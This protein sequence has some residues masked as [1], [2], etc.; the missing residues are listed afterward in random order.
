MPKISYLSDNKEVETPPG[1]TILQVSLETGIPHYY[2]CGGNTRCT[3]CR[4]SILEGLENCFPRNDKEQMVA[5]KLH[6]S[7]AIRLACQTQIWGDIKLRRLV[8]DE[9]DVAFTSQ[10]ILE[11]V[12]SEVLAMHST[13]DFMNIVGVFW[14]GLQDSG[15]YADYCSIEIID[16]EQKIS[17]VYAAASDWLE[18]Q[19]GIPPIKQNI[20]DKIHCYH[21]AMPL[22][23][24]TR[25][26]QETALHSGGASSQETA[27][28]IEFFRSAWSE[29]IPAE[30]KLPKSWVVVPFSYGV[31]NILSFRANRF[32]E[33]AENM[34]R[35]FADAVSL[36]YT[37]LLD[38][39]RLEQRNEELQRTYRQLRDTQT[40]LLQ[41]A[42]LASLGRLVSGVAH[43]INSPLGALKSSVDTYIRSFEKI[44]QVLDNNGLAEKT[45]S[46]PVLA[47]IFRSLENLNQTAGASIQRID[48]VVSGL[49]KFSHLDRA[50]VAEMDIHEGINEA[51]ALSEHQFRERITVHK[52]FGKLPKI[53]AYPGQLNQAFL[54]LLENAHEAIRDRGEIYIKTYCRESYV[55]IEFRDTGKGIAPEHLPQIF[56]PGFTTKGVG[57][58]TGMGLSILYKIIE[59]HHGKIEVESEPGKGSLFRLQL[60]VNAPGRK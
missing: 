59:N 57:V 42:K 36:A 55:F 44:R 50:E 39:R 23:Q 15:I 54:N 40:E 13:V 58:G 52:E 11:R 17:E 49:R 16:E 12:R 37:R 45:H 31:L 8:L 20:L 41:S 56:D 29:Q 3:T 51:L 26:C 6:F 48:T 4:V 32:P 30:E 35:S 2:V 18:K 43:E 47:K 19:Y 10:Q 22:T 21:R 1:K 7:P 28:Y 60:P 25:V 38:F 46:H 24:K 5:E 34:L 27:Q 53:N 9:D 33:N 14:E